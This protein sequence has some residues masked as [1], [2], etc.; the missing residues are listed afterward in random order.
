MIVQLDTENAD[1]NLTALVTCLTHTPSATQAMWCQGLVKLGDG[2]KNLDGSGG[3]FQAVVTVGGNTLQ[4][5]PQVVNF[6][7]AVRAALMTAP[8]L[9]PANDAVTL[10]VK[11][12]NG[13][14]TDVDATAYLYEVAPVLVSSG[15]VTVG[16]NDDKTGY[17]L[18]AAYDDAKNAAQ[19][20]E[21]MDLVDD[22]VDS[23]ALAASGVA[24]IAAATND[25][26][27]IETSAVQINT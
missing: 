25:T 17:A 24:E 20:G 18:T 3:N 6:G 13:A 5:A 16:T 7:T 11:S 14:D 15:K 9:V 10:A 26:V 21:K 19:P 4:P 27:V 1:R 12:P 8:F 22:A 23:D 2:A